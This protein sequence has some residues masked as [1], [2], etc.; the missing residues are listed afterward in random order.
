M[1]VVIKW[2]HVIYIYIYI[3]KYVLEPGH[4]RHLYINILLVRVTLAIIYKCPDLPSWP[5]VVAFRRPSIT[6]LCC[7]LWD[8]TVVATTEH[9]MTDGQGTRS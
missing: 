2:G 9:V 1:A 7:D 6:T 3:Y 4:A 8:P 5:T